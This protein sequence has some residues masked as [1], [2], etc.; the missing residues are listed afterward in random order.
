MVLRWNEALWTAVRI[1]GVAPVFATRAAAI[2]QAAVY[3]AVNSIDQSH[4]PYLVNIPAPSWA[5]E[6]AAAAE[7]AH[8]ALVGLFPNQATVLDLE[9]RASLQG[10]ADGEAKAWGIQVGHAA[11]QIMLAVR[12]HDGSDRVVTYTPGTNP[13]DWQPTP[14]A[15]GPPLA[16][17]WPQVTPFCLQSASQFRSPPPPALTSPE[18]T[19]AFNQV[20]ELGALDSTTR[21]ADQ[22]EAALF[23]QGIAIANNGAIGQFDQI[24]RIVAV[25]Q[26]NTLV[27]NARLFALLDMAQADLYIAVWDSKYTYNFW[28][29]VTAI[30]AADTTGNPDTE[31]DPTWTPLMATPSHP[32]YP[33]AHATVSTGAATVLADFFGTDAIPFSI[34]YPGLPGVTRSFDSFSA[35]AQE[36][37]QSRIWA[38]FHWSF[39]VSAG[40]AQGQSVGDY[41]F[42]HLL[43]LRGD[44]PGWRGLPAGGNSATGGSPAGV[45]VFV[46]S[47]QP[48]SVAAVPVG[49]GVSGNR[50]VDPAFVSATLPVS[51]ADK[52]WGA[53]PRISSPPSA[54]LTPAV[55][56]PGRNLIGEQRP[57]VAAAR[58]D[59]TLSGAPIQR[60][61]GIDQ[62]F[63]EWDG[64]RFT[65]VAGDDLPM[66]RLR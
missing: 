66:G 20:K 10:I 60:V 31:A 39:D 29:P 33:A 36:A 6:E 34:S 52:A 23:W 58:G 15:F 64:S 4:T 2:T 22:T 17:Q 65:D 50:N 26:G 41:V 14:P 61:E 42:Q 11:A 24:A 12:A 7:A 43:L 19:A 53:F 28:R 9:L 8:D 1:A 32:S 56:L 38:G 51:Q 59:G 40:E 47:T 13:G 54:P 30:R 5:S 37:G 18:Y 35:A 63:A 16:P 3:E 45:S 48:H 25:D 27:D 55:A 57:A 62:L 49:L 44:A 21:T 46:P